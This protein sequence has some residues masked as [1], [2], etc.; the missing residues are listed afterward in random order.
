MTIDAIFT[1]FFFL[2]KLVDNIAFKDGEIQQ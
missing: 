2:N 1:F